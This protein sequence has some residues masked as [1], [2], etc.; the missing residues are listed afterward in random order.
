MGKTNAEWDKMQAITALI[1]AIITIGS[2]VLNLGEAKNKLENL[3]TGQKH[4][5]TELKEINLGLKSLY[6]TT[7]T[8]QEAEKDFAIRDRLWE[9]KYQALKRSQSPKSY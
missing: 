1:L 4:I 9:A 6:T 3:E 7:Y 5:T 8:R 2:I